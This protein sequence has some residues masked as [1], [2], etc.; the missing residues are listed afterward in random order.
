MITENNSHGFESP[1]WHYLLLIMLQK[2]DI[3]VTLY[4]TYATCYFVFISCYQDT[5]YTLYGHVLYKHIAVNISVYIYLISYR[6]ERSRF[7]A[8][9]RSEPSSFWPEDQHVIHCT[10]LETGNTIQYEGYMLPYYFVFT[11]L[12]IVYTIFVPAWWSC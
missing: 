6:W 8:Y 3:L 9:T 5:Y 1:W 7:C 4:Y 2:T 11:F 12:R 10:K